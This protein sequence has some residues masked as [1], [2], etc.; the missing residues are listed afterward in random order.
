MSQVYLASSMQYTHILGS[1][2]PK[3]RTGQKST[4]LTDSEDVEELL[5]VVVVLDGSGQ[6]LPSQGGGE[7]GGYQLG[8]LLNIE[9]F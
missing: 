6:L 5:D 8:N 2:T 9:D 7:A 4:N 1:S 3:I